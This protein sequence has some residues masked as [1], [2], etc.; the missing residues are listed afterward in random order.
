MLHKII[1]TMVCCCLLSVPGVFASSVKTVYLSPSG[2]DKN[3]G[4]SINSSVATLQRALDIATTGLAG[5][6]KSVKVLVASGVYQNQTAVIKKIPGGREIEIR[7]LDTEKNRPQFDGSGIGGTWLAL[8]NS[9]GAATRLGVYGLEVVNYH[10]AISFNGNRDN[11][12]KSNS[13]NIV[14]NNVFR[15]IGQISHPGSKPA[16]AAIRLVNSDRNMIIRN[17]FI[18]IRNIEKCA[19][20]HAIYIAHDSTDNTIEENIFE[21]SCG[22]AIRFRD[23]S[24]NNTV[25]N[26]RFIDAW[27]K[28]PISDWYCESDKRNDCT[29]ASGECPSLGNV[30][31]SNSVVSKKA[32]QVPLILTY[33]DDAPPRCGVNKTGTR[34]VNMH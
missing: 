19:L 25:K 31:I 20:L 29:K 1:I 4:Y 3:D 22:D 18:T 26:N 2:A 16:T 10:T 6:L 8:S 21:D 7:P 24:H 33:G 11:T 17:K 15:N 23:A 30:L 14:R 27:D 34:F 12:A 28:A 13:E 32:K 5:N 9:S